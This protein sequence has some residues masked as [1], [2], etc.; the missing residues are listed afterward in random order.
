MK[1]LNR[2][3]IVKSTRKNKK[4][5]VYENG[6]YLLSFGDNRYAQ[7]KDSTGLGVYTHL[8]HLDRDRRRLYYARHGK[9]AE[10]YTAK[11][12]SHFFLW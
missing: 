2:F 1:F 9:Y 7:Y 4:Y 3:E 6:K 12:F 11:W 5:D 8:N 10:P